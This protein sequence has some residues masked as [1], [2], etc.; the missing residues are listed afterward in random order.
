MVVPALR[1]DVEEI[2]SAVSC[3][4]ANCREEIKLLARRNCCSCFWTTASIILL[5]LL[6][7]EMGRYLVG[8][9]LE[10]LLCIGV[11]EAVFHWLGKMPLVKQRSNSRQRGLASSAQHSLR[12]LVGIRSGPVAL[13]GFRCCRSFRTCLGLKTIL[14]NDFDVE[15]RTWGASSSAP[16][17]VHFSANV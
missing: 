16:W 6:S 1:Q 17:S 11:T 14:S 2:S 5:M 7:R 8:S 4:E 9:A 13:S 12:T 10:P 3:S 15:G